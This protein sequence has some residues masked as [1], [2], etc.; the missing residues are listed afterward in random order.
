MTEIYGT[1]GPA[2]AS[3]DILEDMLRAGMTGMR[4]NLSHCDLSDSVG[5]IQAYHAA[6]ATVKKNVQLVVDT[7]GPELRIGNLDRPVM[8]E[9]GDTVALGEDR[10]PVPAVVLTAL[11]DSC[12]VLLDDGKI[13]LRV[14][15]AKKGQAQ[16]VRGGVLK[17]R[18][19][20]KL[21]GKTIRL[22]VL[23]ERDIRNIRQATSFGVTGLLQPFVHSG[24]EILDLR[25][26]LQENGAGHLQIF[27]KIETLEGVAHLSDILPHADVLVIARGD[28][29]NDMPLWQ[30]PAVQKDIASICR[31]A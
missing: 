10:I 4:L 3:Q 28:L 17:G 27:A 23:T 14:T 24:E 6:A 11:E 13:A 30:L 31:K 7:Q 18:K 20:I 16:V 2:C 9:E 29:G 5:Q 15:D 26:I 21:P 25:N 1:F 22:P 12:Q 8:L 19:S